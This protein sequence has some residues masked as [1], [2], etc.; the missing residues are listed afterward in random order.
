MIFFGKHN[1]SRGKNIWT[2]WSNGGQ[3]T[4]LRQK[5]H[6]S[7]D[8][9]HGRFTEEIRQGKAIDDLEWLS[10]F[11]PWILYTRYAMCLE[12]NKIHTLLPLFMTSL[13]IT[14]PSFS[15]YHTKY[16]ISWK[17][18]RLSLFITLGNVCL[19]QREKVCIAVCDVNSVMS[20]IY[21]TYTFI[22]SFLSF[23]ISSVVNFAPS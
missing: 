22:C 10:T 20:R 14:N 8:E 13:F 11:T 4:G 6:T 23:I 5:S 3:K 9:E 1:A 18:S 12:K 21:H 16:N 7:L 17:I 15:I 2:L 19:W